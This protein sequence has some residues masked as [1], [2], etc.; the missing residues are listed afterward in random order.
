MVQETS[1][2]RNGRETST[3]PPRR[4]PL[5]ALLRRSAVAWVTL[6]ALTL[7]SRAHA[8]GLPP[9][10]ARFLEQS[11]ALNRDELKA[12]VSG[13]PVVKVLEPADHLEIAVFGIVR[14]GVPRSFYV[15]SAANFAS[16]LR[17]PWRL[18]FA[19]FSDPASASDV[20]TLS[21]PHDEVEK[22]ADCVPGS[23]I[24]KVPAA[25]MA[26]FR[27][28]IDPAS[29][30]AD[31]VANTLFRTRMVEYVT[32]YRA[33]GDSALIV[34]DDQRD[35]A[36][37]AQVFA[38]MLSRSPYMYQ[39]APSLERY[40]KNYPSDRPADLREALFWSED[41]LPKLRPTLSIT[42]EIVYAPPEL[43][44]CTFIVGKLLYADHYLNGALDLTA[45]VDAMRDRQTDPAGIYLV[46]LRRLHFDLLPSGG[47]INVRGKVKGELR[48]RTATWLRDAKVHSERA[49]ANTTTPPR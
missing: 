21:L 28:T 47:P 46:V 44:D 25:T 2:P 42:Q 24:V 5:A 49:Y 17:N 33:H 16:S 29:P 43:A 35:R 12:A 37:A 34:Y 19:L 8:Q 1:Q 11:I 32:A 14:I 30:S 9:S 39:Y 40:L 20:A 18:R 4:A 6:A 26:R 41:D 10:L 27:A 45:V 3:R 36:E 31:S 38:A 23:C 22:M 15:D 13:K 48:D 7:P